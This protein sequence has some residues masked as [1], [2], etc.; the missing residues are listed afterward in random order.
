MKKCWVHKKNDE[1]N[2]PAYCS[3][4]VVFYNTTYSLIKINK[5]IPDWL[6]ELINSSFDSV[7]EKSQVGQHRFNRE[8]LYYIK[9]QKQFKPLCKQEDTIYAEVQTKEHK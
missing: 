2:L 7:S 3:M 1:P 5:K 8:Q 6:Q 4:F 9:Y